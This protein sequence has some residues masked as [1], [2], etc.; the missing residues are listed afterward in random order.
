MQVYVVNIQ[1]LL[2][3]YTLAQKKVKYCTNFENMHKTCH[4]FLFAYDINLHFKH[5]VYIKKIL[6]KY[7]NACVNSLW[8]KI[9]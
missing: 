5:N 4:F 6:W 3:L 2:I 7:C 1:K 8:V 9:K